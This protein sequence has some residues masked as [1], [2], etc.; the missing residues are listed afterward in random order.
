MYRPVGEGPYPAVLH[1]HGSGD[2]VAN[3]V[4]ILQRF[5]RAGYVESMSSIVPRTAS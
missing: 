4:D 3:N 5:A 1:L 2:T